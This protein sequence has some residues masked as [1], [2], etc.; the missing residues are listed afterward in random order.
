[1]KH[2]N[3]TSGLNFV[4]RVGNL[5]RVNDHMLAIALKAARR[6]E[7]SLTMRDRVMAWIRG[8]Y[9]PALHSLFQLQ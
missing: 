7:N 5:G 1:M 2:L 4:E 8:Q 3:I 9:L 6:H